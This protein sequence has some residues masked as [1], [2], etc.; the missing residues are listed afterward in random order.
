MNE[1]K[2]INL[3]DYFLNFLQVKNSRA[4]IETLKQYKI[5]G[6]CL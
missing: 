1:M 5:F 4:E 2:Y 6:S 3:Y